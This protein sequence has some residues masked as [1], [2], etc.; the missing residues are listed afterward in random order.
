M[1]SK[2]MRF[3]QYFWKNR[4]LCYR[5]TEREILSR[6][7][8]SALGVAWSFITPLA[9]LTVYTF[10][11]S[12]VFKA[13]WGEIEQAGPLG[14]AVNL[15]AGLIVFN[16]FSECIQKAPGLILAYPNYVKKVVFPLEILGYVVIGSSFFHAIAS[17]IILIIFKII[18]FQS[19]S[20]T[21]LW[22]PLVWLPL[23]LGTLSC[24]WILSA[25]GVFIRDINQIVGICLNM[26]MF[27]SPIFFPISAL[28]ER[29]RP[30]LEINPLAQ[31]IEQ[32]R[33]VAVQDTN[34][35]LSYLVI[36]TFIGLVSCEVCFRGFNKSKKAFAD[37]L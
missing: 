37:V 22:L 25:L 26:L 12:Q 13:R 8:G 11:F 7:R 6:Y 15:F 10:I 9:M 19:L 30:L 18:A 36:G 14:F 24:T 17:L 34:P 27:L 32:T 33:R 29:W 16:I 23:M 4:D 3:P 1:K 35:S 21:L 20:L 31:V 2:I 5:L 28:P